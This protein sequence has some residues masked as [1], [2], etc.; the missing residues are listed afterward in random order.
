MRDIWFGVLMTLAVGTLLLD[1]HVRRLPGESY[2]HA[3]FFI[4]QRE[5]AWGVWLSA[6]MCVVLATRVEVWSVWW[7]LGVPV[8]LAL[9]TW[10]LRS[11]PGPRQRS[12]RPRPEW[13]ATDVE[14]HSNVKRRDG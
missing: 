4:N 1:T 14:P 2:V 11:R 8:P 10:W 12:R 13:L 5:M 6:I 9:T 3:A 7:A